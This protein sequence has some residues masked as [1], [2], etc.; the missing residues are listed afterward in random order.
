MKLEKIKNYNIQTE[1]LS[2]DIKFSYEIANLFEKTFKNYRSF[3]IYDEQNN[4]V[5]TIVKT[6]SRLKVYESL[7]YSWHSFL[8]STTEKNKA[9][10]NILSLL[11]PDSLTFSFHQLPTKSLL[12]E[13]NKNNFVL[14][15]S[16]SDFLDLTFGF[17]TIF[18]DSFSVKARN[19][20]RK[21]LKS[22][23]KFFLTKEEK[24]IREYFDIYSKTAQTWDN[25]YVPYPLNFYLR[26]IKENNN[27]D[28]WVSTHNDK[29]VA[30]IITI[31]YS[32]KIYYWASMINRD[33]SKL[34]PING[35]LYNAI[36]FYTEEG[37]KIFDFGPS[38]KGKG[39]SHFKKNFGTEECIFYSY[40]YK[41]FR[42]RNIIEPFNK[43]R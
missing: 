11:K 7:P 5:T 27:V 34:C 19:Q 32:E 16:K 29:L 9:V 41:S 38:P 37:Y 22:E 26:L 31:K 40:T 14:T 17:E 36:Q 3:V 30:G 20:C 23:L 25:A 10:K 2:H 21:A 15:T 33:Y 42:Y 43:L 13:F 28:F 35:L 39:V 1:T 6:P 4:L 18:K 12:E 8:I 24:R